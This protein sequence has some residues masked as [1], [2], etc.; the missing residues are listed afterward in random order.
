MK[1]TVS[2]DAE[3]LVDFV[4]NYS[5]EDGNWTEI[6]LPNG[7]EEDDVEDEVCKSNVVNVS[8]YDDGEVVV[9]GQFTVHEVVGRIP[10]SGGAKGEPPINPPEN[11]TRE[12]EMIFSV[13]FWFKGLGETSIRVRPA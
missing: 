1:D 7:V 6:T 5:K 12:V 10:A 11:E 13:H 8:G 2:V 3:S 9:T 4:L